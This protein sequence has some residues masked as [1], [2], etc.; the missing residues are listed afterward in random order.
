[1]KPFYSMAAFV[2]LMLYTTVQVSAQA[3][4]NVR[5]TIDASAPN[6][7]TISPLVYGTNDHYPYA[8]AKRMGGNRL[9]GYN[10]E[11]NASNAGFDWYHQ[12][13]NWVPAQFN[14]P[15]DQYDVPG[16]SLVAF[17]NQSLQQGAYS[18]A[19]LPMAGFV[20]KD[21]TGIEVSE[22]QAATTSRWAERWNRVVTRKPGGGLSLT[23]NVNDNEVYVDEELNFLI[24]RYGRSNTANGI[25]AYSLDNEPCLWFHSHSRLFGHTGVSVNYLMNK[26]YETAELIKEM[27]PTAE[28]YGPALW[29]YTAYQNLQFAPDWDQVRGNYDLFVHY[30][31][32]KMRERSQTAGRRLL[33][34]LDLHWYPAQNRDW[35]GVSPFDD[36]NDDNSVGARVDMSR[37]LWDDTYQEN[38]WVTDASNGNIFPALPKMKAMID[39]YY[40]GTKLAITEY[41][42]GGTE[43]VSGVVA[44]ADALGAFGIHDVYLATYWG[45]LIGYIKSGFDLFCN[46][47]GN[48][49]R[50]GTTAV[51]AQTNNR[52]VSAVYASINGAND[53]NM[54]TMAINRSVTDTVVATIVISGARQYRSASVYAVDRTSYQVRRLPDVRDVVNNT[55]NVKMPPM[56]VYHLV[57][58]ETDLTVYPFITDL[59]INP[60]QGY[61]DG[62]ARF[63]ISAT[64]TDSDNDMRPP[65]VDLRP[66]GGNAA[67]PLVRNGDNYTLEYTVPA[68]TASGIKTLT[69]SAAD[70]AGHSVSDNVTYRVMRDIPSTVIWDGDAIRTGEGERANDPNDQTAGTML[71]ER[72]ANGGNEA[73]GSL[74]LRFKHDPNNWALMTWR[75]HPSAAEARDVSEFGYLEFYIRSTAPAYA[76]IDFSLRDASANM[77]VSHTVQLK[78]DGYISAFNPTQFTKVKIP[79]ADLVDGTGFDLTRLWQFNFQVNTAQA[80]FEVWIDDV[81][82]LPYDNPVAQ[83]VLTDI[84]I[85]P[86]AGFADGTT[87]VT[88]SAIATDPN[89]DLASVTIDLSSIGGA[90]NHALVLT[91]G[92]YTTTFTVPPVAPPGARTLN[93]TAKDQ[94][95][96]TAEGSANYYVWSRA[97]SDII[98]DGDTK[99]EGSAEESSNAQSRIFVAQ[100][101][102]N[103]GPISM[104]AHLQPNPEPFAFV[105]WDF[106]EFVDARM[107][108]VRQKRYLNFSVLVPNGGGRQDFDLQIYF[109]D[110]FGESTQVLG[111]KARGYLTSYTG[112]YQDVR[113][114]IADLLANSAIDPSKIAWMGLLS[115]R[116]PNL[117]THVQL[118]DIYLSGNPVADV[119]IET[120]PA[121]CL[122][123]GRI[124]VKSVTS[125]SGNYRYSLAGGAFQ[126]SPIFNNLRAGTYDLRIEGD[127][128]FV[129]VETIVLTGGPG[130]QGN[131][132]VDNATGNVNLT[133]TSGSGNYSYR[134]SNNATTEDL[135]NVA[136]GA[137]TVNVTDNVTGCTFT[138]VANVARTTIQVTYNLKPAQCSPNG[139]I[140]VNPI[141]GSGNIR[142]FIDGQPNPRGADQPM[143]TLLAPGTYRIRVTGDNGLDNTQDV[144]LGGTLMDY[145]IGHVVNQHHGDI[146]ITITGGSGNFRYN[147]S[148]GSTAQ[149]LRGLQNGTY[150]LEVT[151]RTSQCVTAIIFLITRIGPDVTFSSTAADCATGGTIT[152]NMTGVSAGPY[153]FFINGQLN[154]AGAA[155]NVFRNLQTEFYDIRVTGTNGYEK[156]GNVFVDGWMNDMDVQ[157][158]VNQQT[159]SID[160]TVTGG[161]GNF[162]YTWSNNAT[163]QDVTGLPSGDYWVEID[164][165]DNG[166]IVRHTFVITRPVTPTITFTVTNAACG[167]NGVIVTNLSVGTPADFGYFINGH[168][169]PAGLHNPTFRNLAPG[170]YE[171]RVAGDGGFSNLQNVTVGGSLNNIRVIGTADDEG[172]INISVSGGSGNYTY[173]WSDKSE[174]EDL[175]QRAPG[176]Y[177]V[178]VTDNVSGCT[179]QFSVLVAASQ[180]TLWVYPNPAQEGFR[181]KYVIPESNEM[182]LTLVDLFGRVVSRQVLTTAQGNIYVSAARLRSGMYFVQVQSKEHKQMRPIIIAK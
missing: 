139:I 85:N 1:M 116:L 166:C 110:R 131:V 75:I 72:R 127:G 105:T 58:S 152:V 46:Y 44:Q 106:A 124:E 153:Q 142:Y 125:T 174:T 53:V 64:I 180:E 14:T 65:T 35:G 80:G 91:N 156:T 102:G 163:T 148:N 31:L 23:P 51:S 52:Q 89:N 54:H 36:D 59:R 112:N 149:D 138:A 155:S 47:D 117:G 178:T 157:S 136:S 73:P 39:Q 145:S 133:I 97:S 62:T 95:G 164:D 50:Y 179:A 96:N 3:V 70:A 16:S 41:S 78:A 168:E 87:P 135:T 171:I 132:Q 61:S 119:Q 30:Y 129:Y 32:A 170:T 86:A 26:S 161:S 177:T 134:W 173:L 48:G 76:D 120:Q 115:E 123:N 5:F 146:D 147:W 176:L 93:I 63:T 101:G 122:T 29:G 107:I 90:N 140:T 55:F 42:Y 143:F 69:I 4:R 154:P 37:G 103:K 21:K 83:P 169:N 79:F 8:T 84:R 45:G 111:L 40:P 17:H 57:L 68:N 104:R 162:R 11:N 28:V 128:G 92:R 12:S 67:T 24:N 109:K 100:T 9:T 77:T 34:V 49:G 43:H 88:V 159:G 144:I 160:L 18:I 33:D 121:V 98:W 181:V 19:T 27:D 25:K 2:F 172:N 158:Q 108:D 6:R 141:T 81:R 15:V 13:D 126:A 94:K 71:V 99:N 7:K 56:S 182:T 82:A 167:A 74:Y 60:A 20:A 113:I 118:D 22:A 66:V 130:V 137:Y 38:S 175:Q 151:D 10:W 114:P 165:V 150:S